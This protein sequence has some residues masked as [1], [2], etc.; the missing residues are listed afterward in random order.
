MLWGVWLFSGV[1]LL[2][3]RRV[4]PHALQIDCI[5]LRAET[6]EVSTPAASDMG[7]VWHV[8]RVSASSMQYKILV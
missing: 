5:D 7:R 1:G 6:A 3:Y 4:T 2:P 8:M